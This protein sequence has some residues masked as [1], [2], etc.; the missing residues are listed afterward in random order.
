MDGAGSSNEPAGGD[1]AMPSGTHRLAFSLTA[2][3]PFGL[4]AGAR[5]AGATTPGTHLAAASD[6][7][8]TALAPL[9]RWALAPLLR[10]ALAPLLRWALAPLLRWALAPLLRWALA[11][12]LPRALAPLLRWA[13]APLLRSLTVLLGSG[14]GAASDDVPFAELGSA[15]VRR[16]RTDASNKG[17]T[18]H[19]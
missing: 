8:A 1:G 16:E 7:A 9:L 10:W 13:L 11:P 17:A 4:S 6:D 12:L 18:S 3:S 5:A 15:H 14:S 19:L 2:L